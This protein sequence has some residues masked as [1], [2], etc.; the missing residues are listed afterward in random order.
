MVRLTTILTFLAGVSFGQTNLDYRLYSKAIQDFIDLGAKNDVSTTEVVVI[1]KYLPSES[2]ISA[3]GDEILDGD[4]PL[5]QMAVHYDTSKIRVLKN[6]HV[7]RAIKSL[8]EIFL[9]TPKLDGRSLMLR[10]ATITITNQQFQ[11]YFKSKSGRQIE[12]GWKKFYRQHRGAHGVFEFS[13]IAYEDEYACFYVGRHSSPLS[14]SGD[15]VIMKKRNG[16]WEVIAYINLW[17]S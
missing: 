8:G 15:V 11:N 14:G 3:Y 17:V 12:K 4:N 7:K 13:K 9:D 16:N 10:P 1:D 2:M 6:E 5:I